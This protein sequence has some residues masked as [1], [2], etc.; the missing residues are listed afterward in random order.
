MYT[1]DIDHDGDDNDVSRPQAS[2][3]GQGSN[4]ASAQG[5]SEQILTTKRGKNLAV[6]VLWTYAFLS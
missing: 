2:N 4:H 6:K 3:G 5:Q 1:V